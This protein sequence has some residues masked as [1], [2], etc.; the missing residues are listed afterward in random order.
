MILILKI[1][2]LALI[3]VVAV[4][5]VKQTKPEIALLIGVAGSILIF[6]Y[7]IDLLE[8]AFGV[9]SYV[10]DVTGLNSELFLVLLKIIGIGY[11][12]EFS[13]NLCADSGNSAVA[14]KIMLAGKLV[15]FVLA[16]PIIKSLID[17]IVSIMP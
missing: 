15:I 17:I 3:V 5:V 9:F 10:L 4:M 1:I 14:S 12:T 16:I 13:A 2:G 8:Q 7:I 6:F 11:L